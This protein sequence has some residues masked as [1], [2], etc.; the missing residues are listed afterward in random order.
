LS[1]CHW[2]NLLFSPAPAYPDPIAKAAAQDLISA[3]VSRVGAGDT[4]PAAMQQ[5]WW[6]QML[7]FVRNP[8]EVDSILNALESTAKSVYQ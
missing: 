3:K 6:K 2:R 8:S 4:M 7:A 1:N 5:A